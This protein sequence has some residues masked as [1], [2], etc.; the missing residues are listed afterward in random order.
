[1]SDKSA[2]ELL[3]NNSRTN[4]LAWL[5]AMPFIGY[6]VIIDV[7][8]VNIVLV[9][10]VVQTSLSQD[11]YTVSLLYPSS[12]L[13]EEVIE[14]QKDDL[15]ILFFLNRF[16]PHMFDDPQIR[17]EEGGE[18]TVY[19]RNASGY[20]HFSGVGM[21]MSAAKG[22]AAM[23]IQHRTGAD[24]P[25]IDAKAAAKLA[26]AF[27]KSVS[28]VFDGEVST[29]FSINAPYTESHKAPV[30]R[31]YGIEEQHDGSFKAFDA[32]VHEEYGPSS[33]VT[34]NIQGSVN[35]TVG[36]DN[37]GNATDAPVMVTLRENS[38]VSITSG[39]GKTEEYAEAVSLKCDE[40]I[41][42]ETGD[43]ITIKN[44][45]QVL[46]AVLSDLIQAVSDAIT[47]GS[48]TTQSMSPP[49]IAAL[50]AIK[51]RCESLLETG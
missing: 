1:M 26:A 38:P 51:Q 11:V 42:I 20:D 24:G 18:T 9:K 2:F 33:P 27:E 17:R 13:K 23:H 21:L 31:L 19:D 34:K 32:P 6:G 15:V 14:P 22:Y 40:G 7:I 39:A 43:K 30:T 12:A 48:P 41:S 3:K 10:E 5:K 46:G 44:S 28:A 4:S 45:A 37:E 29:G 47:V 16:N 50:S 25:E 36:A 8:D 49:T 35:I